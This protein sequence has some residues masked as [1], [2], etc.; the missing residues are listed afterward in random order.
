MKLNWNSSSILRRIFAAALSIMITLMGS[1]TCVFAQEPQQVIRVGLFQNP[2]EIILLVVSGFAILIAA[3]LF[4]LHKMYKTLY[5]DALTGHPNY[6]ALSRDAVRLIGNHP[7]Q[8]ALVYMDIR[9]FKVINDTFGYAAGD[10]VLKKTADALLDFIGRSERVARLHSDVFVMLLHC[11]EQTTLPVRLELLSGRLSQLTFAPSDKIKPLYKAGI[12]PLN[13]DFGDLEVAFDRAHYAKDSITHLFSNT[14]VFYNDVIHIRALQEKELEDSMYTA[15]N[16]GEF[17]PY[18]QPKVNALTEKVIGAE[19]LV[20]WI[21]PEKGCLPPSEFIPFYE[22]NG[23]IVNIDLSIF[24]HVCCDMSQWIQADTQVVPISVNLSRRNIQNK[25][26]P[27]KLK[28]I[29]DRHHVPSNLIELEI[30]ETEELEDLEAAVVFVENLRAYGFKISIDDYGTGYSSISFLQRLPMDALK[31]DRKFILNAMQSDKAEDIMRYLV[32]TMQKNGIR[33]LCEGIETEKQRD[34][35]IGLNCRFIQGFLYSPPLSQMEFESYLQDHGMELPS[36][37][38]DIPLIDFENNRLTGVEDFLTRT[39]PSWVMVCIVAQGYP[40]IYTSPNLF[41]E[42][43]YSQLEFKIATKGQYVNAVHP[44]DLP[45]TL[46]LLEQWDSK[47]DITLQ[48]RLRR[49]DGSYLWVREV[50]KHV[51]TVDGREALLG[52][53][54]NITDIITMEQEKLTSPDA[55]I[56]RAK[57]EL[58]LSLTGQTVLEYNIRTR[59]I[60]LCGG[61]PTYGIEDGTVLDSVEDLFESGL[62]YGEDA[63]KLPGT[64]EELMLQ[65]MPV[66]YEIRVRT[67]DSEPMYHWRR[68]TLRL[69]SDKHGQPTCVVGVIESI[70]QQKRFE[71]AF[72]QEAQYRAA[73]TESS[74]MAYEINLSQD[75]IQRISGSR[76]FRLDEVCRSTAHPYRYSE[77]LVLAVQLLVA[78][79]DREL[80]LQALSREGLMELYQSS[81]FQKELEYR[82]Y[83]WDN[84]VIWTSVLVYLLMDQL[85]GEVVAYAYHRDINERKMAEK[86]LIEQAERDPLTDVLNRVTAEHRIQELLSQPGT[87]SRVQAFLMLDLNRFKAINDTYGHLIGDKCLIRLAQILKENIQPEDIVARMGG[88]EFS[89]FLVDRPDEGAVRNIAEKTAREFTA[90][91]YELDI[92]LPTSVSIG[93]AL[94][95]RHGTDFESLYCHADKE[96]YLAKSNSNKAAED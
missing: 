83:T 30:T 29:A 38:D 57:L 88:D 48:Y 44:D 50:N 26:L 67:Q 9:R 36:C 20:R 72:Q 24:E 91:A 37:L 8:Y 35:I 17:V 52:I 27:H 6:R 82:R 73:F 58:A 90:I 78:D 11:D 74:L 68:I 80:F 40:I 1:A 10:S 54:T 16:N 14:F 76:G 19:A 42:L 94:A 60:S 4:L 55:G 66:S 15:L 84:Q 45:Q 12:Y 32:S 93:I 61:S 28:E 53:C 7:E 46:A 75:T 70:D 39:I 96:M 3:L 64:I 34:F 63:K 33:I 51:L 41:V 77:S 5:T 43:G 18:Y 69:I 79:E 85:S 71:Y 92:D 56:E 81:V 95:P 47:Q 23:F 21:H 89:L 86:E 2:V 87:P 49:K 31:L 22:K 25:E 62:I 65:A 59:I 13:K